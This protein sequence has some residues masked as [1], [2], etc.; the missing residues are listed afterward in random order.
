M[1]PQFH[2]KGYCRRPNVLLQIANIIYA[3]RIL[4]WPS[5]LCVYI[6]IYKLITYDSEM[7]FFCLLIQERHSTPNMEVK[8]KKIMKSQYQSSINFID[9]IH[10]TQSGHNLSGEENEMKNHGLISQKQL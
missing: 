4:W 8:K 10:Q 5:L 6:H 1:L 7:N 2:E 9:T 3:L